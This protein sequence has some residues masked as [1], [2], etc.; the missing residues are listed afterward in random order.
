MPNLTLQALH[1]I[2]AFQNSGKLDP[3]SAHQGLVTTQRSM[4]FS[5]DAALPTHLLELN[6]PLLRLCSIQSSP[7][8]AEETIRRF[9]PLRL[10]I[11]L[12]ITV[13]SRAKAV[14]WQ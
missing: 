8:L 7:T 5:L 2:V 10:E 1:K 6:S 13:D 11:L 4:G 3:D 9:H 12:K 14:P